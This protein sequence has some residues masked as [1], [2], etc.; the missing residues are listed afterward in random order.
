MYGNGTIRQTASLVNMTNDTIFVYEEVTGAIKEIEIAPSD[1]ELPEEPEFRKK[2]DRIH[3]V[4]EPRIAEE[5]RRGGRPLSDVAIVRNKSLGRDGKLITRLV[6]G[7]N[8]HIEVR[9]FNANNA[10][11]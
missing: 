2:D 4:C 1:K 10:A 3:Y 5:I 9:L 7:N 8:P 6:W 11:Y